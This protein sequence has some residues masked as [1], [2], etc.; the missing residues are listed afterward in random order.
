[1][2]LFSKTFYLSIASIMVF[3]I[4]A[5]VA[6]SIIG[7]P[8]PA[9]YGDDDGSTLFYQPE[10]LFAFEVLDN[11]ENEVNTAFGFYSASNPSISALLFDPADKG[12]GSQSAF[13][14]FTVGNVIDWDESDVP[15]SNFEIQDTFTPFAGSIGFFVSFDSTFIYSDPNLNGGIDLAATFESQTDPGQY[16]IG[17][18]LP[19][20]NDFET[21]TMHFMTNLKPIPEPATMVL[22]AFG[23]LSV[24]RY[25][26]NKTVS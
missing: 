26:R 9:G 3:L 23:L 4:P 8:G 7:G 21:I 24:A 25:T 18:E 14:D 6:A 16:I 22:F 20:G 17:F 10:N 13:V 12:F 19:V 5:V 11:F 1:M 2:R 15:N